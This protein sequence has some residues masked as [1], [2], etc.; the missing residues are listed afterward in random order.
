MQRSREADL[1]SVTAPSEG[2]GKVPTCSP[3]PNAGG[4]GGPWS[5]ERLPSGAVRNGAVRSSAD[6]RSGAGSARWQ[7]A[8]GLRSAVPKPA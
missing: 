5:E 3:V 6:C 4:P 8:E 2:R 1:L 7:D